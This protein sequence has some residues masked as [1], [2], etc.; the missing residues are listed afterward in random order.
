MGALQQFSLRSLFAATLVVAVFCWIFLYLPPAMGAA[1][2]WTFALSATLSV[3]VYGRGKLRAFAIGCIAPMLWWGVM[4]GALLAA[5]V[6]GELLFAFV[7]VT[8]LCGYISTCAHE[9]SLRRREAEEEVEKAAPTA[10]SLESPTA[11]AVAP[12]EPTVETLGDKPVIDDEVFHFI[13]DNRRYWSCSACRDTFISLQVHP[14][15]P[16]CGSE[17]V[18]ERREGREIRSVE[19]FVTRR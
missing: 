5:G 7:L 17:S 6:D 16:R 11:S 1:L 19:S 18:Q 8:L 12:E 9:W 13:E 2:V 14:S 10:P 4:G 3:V 15:C